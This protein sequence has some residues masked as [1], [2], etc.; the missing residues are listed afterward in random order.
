MFSSTRRERCR[1]AVMVGGSLAAVDG[2]S[3][4]CGCPAG[5]NHPSCRQAQGAGGSCAPGARLYL[6]GWTAPFALQLYLAGWTAPFVLLLS[7]AGSAA[8]SA[9]PL[10]PAPARARSSRV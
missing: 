8:P 9:L 3:A 2:L 10:R 5:A 1:G 7:L 6:A 4:R